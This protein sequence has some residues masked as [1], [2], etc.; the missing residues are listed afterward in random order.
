MK[1][2]LRIRIDQLIKDYENT[3]EKRYT[4]TRDFY[5]NVAI[6]LLKEIL[7]TEQ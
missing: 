4:A 2:D 1:E 3:T 6:G 7:K 5:L